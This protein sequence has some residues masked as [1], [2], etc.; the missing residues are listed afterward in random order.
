MPACPP[1]VAASHVPILERPLQRK[2]RVQT[3]IPSKARRTRSP[4]PA[5]GR[6]VEVARRLARRVERN[7][8]TA[9]FVI[10]P[11]K[12]ERQIMGRV[13]PKRLRTGRTASWFRGCRSKTYQRTTGFG[14]L[15][16]EDNQTI[17]GLFRHSRGP[18]ET[19]ASGRSGL[20]G[21]CRCRSSELAAW[22]FPSERLR[23]RY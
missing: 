10:L 11:S 17:F 21:V 9:A 8:R 19:I 14:R 15:Q 20:S 23:D 18:R 1:Q 2:S 5:A 22:R 16:S 7:E 3:L 13:A 12:S 6:Y 4:N